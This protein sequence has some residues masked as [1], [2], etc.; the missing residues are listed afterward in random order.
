[1]KVLILGVTGMMGHKLFS[2]LSSIDDF[3]VYSTARNSSNLS[4][5]F[6]QN[7]LDRIIKDVDAYSFDTI[8]RAVSKLKPEVVI[9]CIGLIKQLPIA[10]DTFSAIT[11]NSQL[12]HS[13]SL[14]CQSEGARMI[15][16]STDCVFNGEKGNYSEEDPSDAKDLYG[17]TKYLGEVDY[18]HCVTLR[19]SIIGHELKGRYGL[20]EWFLS[21]KERVKGYTKAVYSGFPTI[22]LARIIGEYVICNNE[23]KGIYHVSSDPISKC[24]LLKLIAEKYSMNT[25]IEPYEDLYI[26]RTLDSTRFRNMTGYSPPSWP[27]L[28]EK[29]RSNYIS[30]YYYGK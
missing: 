12:P 5:W 28:V 7:L 27:A 4:S 19:T 22:E 10:N 13:I 25:I 21:Q 30:S 17:R 1:M 16:I 23:L 8:I 24:E 20:V 18:P 29:M 14:L 11:I 3:D 6:P 15:H 9:N 26:D 2:Y